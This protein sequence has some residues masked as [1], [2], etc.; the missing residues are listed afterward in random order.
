VL[1][2][3][4]VL[5]TGQPARRPI[6]GT[7]GNYPATTLRKNAILYSAGGS[8]TMG[9]LRLPAS[10]SESGRSGRGDFDSGF[11]VPQT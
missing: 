2:L 10:S 11:R 5:Y 4:R 6:L 7:G 3:R 1:S 8:G 9:H